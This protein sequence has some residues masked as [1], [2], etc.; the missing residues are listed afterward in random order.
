MHQWFIFTSTGGL[1]VVLA[2]TISKAVAEFRR[3]KHTKGA[4]VVGVIRAAATM[5]A[6]GGVHPT[7]V[8]GVICCVGESSGTRTTLNPSASPGGALQRDCKGNAGTT[9]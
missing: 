2:D 7:P 1:T 4:D 9:A 6:Y 5:E 3:A 8:F